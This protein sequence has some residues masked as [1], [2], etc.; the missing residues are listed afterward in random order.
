MTITLEN[1]AGAA[2]A[3]EAFLDRHAELQEVLDHWTR[4]LASAAGNGKPVQ[5]VHNLLRFFL[6]DEVLPHTRAAERTLYRVARRDPTAGPLVQALEG[7]HKILRSMTAR[8]S[9]PARPTAIAAQAA[10]IASLFASHVA[11]ENTLLLALE[12]S[13]ADLAALLAREPVLASS[14]LPVSIAAERSMMTVAGPAASRCRRWSGSCPQS[15]SSSYC[16]I[17]KAG[18]GRRAP[19][20]A[21]G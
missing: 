2:R 11:K 12:R 14:R 18:G 6:T 17:G 20:T 21:T 7:E 5:P 15:R 9:E 3:R 4:V 19:L 10:A 1:T 16:D 8:L 13:G